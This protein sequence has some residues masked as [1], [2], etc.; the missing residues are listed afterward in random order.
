MNTITVITSTL[1]VL[2]VQQPDNSMISW[3]IHPAVAQLHLFWLSTHLLQE[4][5]T[6]CV[7]LQSEAAANRATTGPGML[8]GPHP[9][10]LDRLSM[11]QVCRV[12]SLNSWLWVSLQVERREGSGGGSLGGNKGKGG[13]MARGLVYFSYH[14][15]HSIRLGL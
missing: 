15:T 2:G 8:A 7:K 3:M 11:M 14:N 4:C 6:S 1:C 13:K 9:R 10:F 5:F 12:G